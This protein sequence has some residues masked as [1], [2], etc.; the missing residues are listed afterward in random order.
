MAKCFTQQNAEARRYLG[1][2]EGLIVFKI[3]GIDKVSGNPRILF[4]DTED[5]RIARKH[6][7]SA[8]ISPQEI[9]VSSS[10]EVPP[11]EKGP[12]RGGVVYLLKC[13]IHFKIGK[14]IKPDQRYAALKIQL[15]E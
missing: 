7:E 1:S 13:G 3:K 11:L 6:A 5:Q 15:P 12:S 8:G 14:S 10:E 2:K 9:M 4:V